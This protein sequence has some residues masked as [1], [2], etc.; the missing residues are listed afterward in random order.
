MYIIY[1]YI[2]LGIY[3]YIYIIYTSAHESASWSLVFLVFHVSV[4]VP[5]TRKA[6]KLSTWC[7]R[8]CCA[9]SSDDTGTPGAGTYSKPVRARYVQCSLCTPYLA[10]LSR[11]TW[12][13]LLCSVYLART[14]LLDLRT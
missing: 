1:I 3:I 11:R 14:A 4:F 9:N 7:F 6:S 10:M 12:R 8:A 2:Y 13:E 5:C